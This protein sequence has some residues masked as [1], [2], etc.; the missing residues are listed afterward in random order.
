MSEEESFALVEMATDYDCPADSSGN[1]SIEGC[2]R[3]I[4]TEA[5]ELQ[6]QAFFAATK[7]GYYSS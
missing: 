7:A 1:I 3:I 6:R 2:I 4:M 5:K